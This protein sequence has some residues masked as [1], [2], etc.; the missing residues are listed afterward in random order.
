[1]RPFWMTGKLHMTTLSCP[2]LSAGSSVATAGSGVG[3]YPA[4]GAGCSGSLMSIAWR[5]PECHVT[6][7]RFSVSVGLCEEKLEKLLRIASTLAQ[8]SD[9]FHGSRY[10]AARRGVVGSEMSMK[11]GQPHGQPWAGSRPPSWP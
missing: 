4:A 1:M 11:R 7:A 3:Q 2:E 6:I 10:S 5:P 8:T 9:L